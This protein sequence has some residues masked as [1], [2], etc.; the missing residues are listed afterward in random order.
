VWSFSSPEPE[1][2]TEQVSDTVPVSDTPVD[3]PAPVADVAPVDE[4]ETPV[5]QLGSEPAP[6]AEKVP[7][8]KRELSSAQAEDRE[9]AQRKRRW[10]A[11]AA[12]AAAAITAEKPPLLKRQLSLK[13]KPK[14]PKAA[15]QPKQKRE[16]RIP[17]PS[18]SL[19]LGGRGDHKIT[20]V[21]GL[22][23]G[24]TQ[25]AA[26]HIQNNGTHELMQ[27]ART[28]LDRG[29]VVGGEVPTR[30]RSARAQRVAITSRR[31]RTRGR[32]ASNRIGARARRPAGR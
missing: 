19:K 9:A 12:V 4:P 27:L 14:E 3:E 21:V 7:L 15:S 23:I 29:L 16:L 31:S 26:A 13:R 25:L 30:R 11:A 10:T 18:L 6:A 5:A 22:R 1:L 32:H 28:P 8:L 2:E 17:K 24:S 20:N